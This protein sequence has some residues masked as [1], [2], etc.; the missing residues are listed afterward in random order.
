M[1]PG[2]A[3]TARTSCP[4][5]ASAF[6]RTFTMTASPPRSPLNTWLEPTPLQRDCATHTVSRGEAMR[7]RAD[8][9]RGRR[10]RQRH[11]NTQS[12]CLHTHQVI[13]ASAGHGNVSS[14]FNPQHTNT[15]N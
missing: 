2:T 13:H 15:N 14:H 4:L 11:R 6:D 12:Q 8:A 5:R 9:R 1:C 3:L 7:G 10:A